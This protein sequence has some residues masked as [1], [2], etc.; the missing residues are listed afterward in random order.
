MT[1]LSVSHLPGV[2]NHQL[3][4]FVSVIVREAGGDLDL[5]RGPGVVIYDRGF[6]TEVTQTFEEPF[7]EPVGPTRLLRLRIVA[8]VV[9]VVVLVIKVL[10]YAPVLGEF[11]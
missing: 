5:R 6:L 3:E 1:N 10:F 9:V 4:P 2:T 8:V 7:V 11:V